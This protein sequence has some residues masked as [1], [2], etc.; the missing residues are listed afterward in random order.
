MAVENKIVTGNAE[1]VA[2]DLG[3]AARFSGGIVKRIPFSFEVAAADDNNSV[4]RFARVSPYAIITSIK[5][6]SDATAGMTDTDFGFYK[7]L[8]LGGAAIDKDCLLDGAD[9]NAGKA[10]FTE[11]LVPTIV[12]FGK[13]AFE[14]AGLTE[15]Q[16]VEYGSFDLAMTSVAAASAAGTISGYVDIQDGI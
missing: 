5:L 10:A 2:V 3:L 16:A 6:L 1:S 12:D 9:I 8:E 7:P 14:I 15:A 13:R 4:Y 11:M